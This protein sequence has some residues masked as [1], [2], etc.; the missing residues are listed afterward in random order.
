MTSI[1]E[2][3][4]EKAPA[5]IRLILLGEY[6]SSSHGVAIGSSDHD[7]M[8]IAIEPKRAVFGLDSYEHTVL[9]EGASGEATAADD[10]EGTIYALRKFV[11]LAEQGNTAIMSALYLPHYAVRDEL[12]DYL[13]AHRDL[14]QSRSV[15]KR[16]A[17][18]L[19]REKRRMTGELAEKVLRPQLV[20]EFGFDTKAA[21]QAVKLGF[22]G[23]RFAREG[24]L[25]I[26][27]PKEEREYIISVRRGELA[28]EAVQELL[29]E[30]IEFLDAEA[31]TSTLLPE[32]P[33][34]EK[35]NELLQ[36]L[37]ERAYYRS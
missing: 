12:G 24:R 18:H 11:K 30:T 13:V 1:F 28:T 6:G 21:Y 17:G 14:F 23:R 25:E 33:D 8:G 34:R 31:E 37:Y 7:Y 9:K 15:L 10:N 29:T 19:A 22:H 35:L 32:R 26:P 16:F 2:K 4:R 36:E 20:E 5:D 27:F 3:I